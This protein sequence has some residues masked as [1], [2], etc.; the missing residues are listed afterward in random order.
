MNIAV[1]GTTVVVGLIAAIGIVRRSLGHL[2]AAASFG[3]GLTVAAN[4]LRWDLPAGIDMAL[5]IGVA[6][7]AILVARLALVHEPI[8]LAQRLRFKRPEAREWEFDWKL[9][10]LV[11]EFNEVL[12]LGETTRPAGEAREALRSDARRILRKML[13]LRAPSDSWAELVSM[14]VTL[15]RIHLDEFGSPLPED[16]ERYFRELNGRATVQREMLR[17]RYARPGPATRGST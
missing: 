9:T 6:V 14:Y 11:D 16:L 4:A 13:E 8:W 12:S 2:V 1:V 5:P 15:L 17:A 3:V 7:A 10:K